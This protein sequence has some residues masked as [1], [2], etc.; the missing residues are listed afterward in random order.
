MNANMKKRSAKV[1]NGGDFSDDDKDDK[2][3]Y[4]VHNA[5]LLVSFMSLQLRSFIVLF[6]N[7]MTFVLQIQ[8]MVLLMMLMM[9]VRVKKLI[10]KMVFR[11]QMKRRRAPFAWNMG[12]SMQETTL[13]R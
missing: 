3:E 10:M 4:E 7:N 13:R 5:N 12:W 8:R 11:S 2:Y 1:F 6:M 9:I